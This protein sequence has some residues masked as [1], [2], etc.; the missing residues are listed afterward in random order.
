MDSPILGMIKVFPYGSVVPMGWMV[1]N[2]AILNV[3]ANTALF[4]LIGNR[5]AGGNG[6]TTFALPDL[7]GAEP[8]PNT[9]YCIATQ[10][11][12]PEMP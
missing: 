1:C 2:G 7:R 11:I 12:Y 8:D 4:S 10:G 3:Q 5:F 6:T 9:F